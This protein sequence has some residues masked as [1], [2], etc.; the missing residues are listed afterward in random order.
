MNTHAA[1][2][3]VRG[4]RVLLVAAALLTCVASAWSLTIRE[5]RALEK[6]DPKQGAFYVQYYLI[7]AVEGAIEMQAQSARGGAKPMFCLNGRKPEPRRAK[8]MID[9]ELKRNADVYEADMP[10]E[11]VVVN[12]LVNTYPC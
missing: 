11:L 6:S 9:A 5:M 2:R 7:G 4:W 10:L 3:R 1:S 8:P 12:A